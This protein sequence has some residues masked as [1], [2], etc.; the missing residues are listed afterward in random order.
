MGATLET[1]ALLASVAPLSIN[2]RTTRGWPV[3]ERFEH[4][5][6]PEPNSGCWL[7]TGSRRG[8]RPYGQF[9]MGA[10]GGYQM[11]SAHRAA[12][13]LYRGP[14]LDGLYVLHRC[15]VGACV[16]PAHLFLGTAKDNSDDKLRKERQ[17]RGERQHSSKLTADDVRWIRAMIEVGME[18]RMIARIMGVQAT[19][20]S[21]INRRHIWKHVR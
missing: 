10:V 5:V 19:N 11:V 4:H 21:A 3:R 9:R 8:T 6:M 20:I 15:D 2:R 16:T 14:I 1:L 12:Y 17:V 7:W 18:Q 13:E